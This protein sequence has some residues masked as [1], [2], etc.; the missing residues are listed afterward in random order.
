MLVSVNKLKILRDE[1]DIDQTAGRIFQI[2]AIV[3]ASFRGDGHPHLESIARDGRVRRGG[4]P[5]RR[6]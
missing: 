1:L 6:E 4:A 5:A 2:P 3:L